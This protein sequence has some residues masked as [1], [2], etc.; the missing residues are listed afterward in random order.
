MDKGEQEEQDLTINQVAEI[1][2]VHRKTVEDWVLSGKLAAYQLTEGGR[3]RIR[4]KDLETFRAQR[5]VKP[6]ATKPRTRTKKRG[7]EL[8]VAC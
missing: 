8:S 3:Y 6:R 2:Q 7:E 5:Q 1:V 4:P